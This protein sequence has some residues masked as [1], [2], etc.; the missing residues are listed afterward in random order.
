VLGVPLP[1]VS[2]GGSALITTLAAIGVVL[3]FARHRPESDD[4]TSG[5]LPESDAAAFRGATR[6]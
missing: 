6:R 3:S 1:L 4:T 2:A 5:L